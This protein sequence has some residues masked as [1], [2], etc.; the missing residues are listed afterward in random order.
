MGVAASPSTCYLSS[1]VR[2]KIEAICGVIAVT[3]NL[4]P[5]NAPTSSYQRPSTILQFAGRRLESAGSTSGPIRCDQQTYANTFSHQRKPRRSPSRLD[6]IFNSGPVPTSYHHVEFRPTNSGLDQRDRPP[7]KVGAK[8][9]WLGA[10]RRFLCQGRP[11][12]LIKRR[13]QTGAGGSAWSLS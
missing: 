4:K 7:D 11:A 9:G 2:L 1:Q 3:R 5:S 6:H 8:A 12:T 10:A 13:T